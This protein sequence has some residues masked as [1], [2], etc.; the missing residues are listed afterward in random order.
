VYLC[1]YYYCD[2]LLWSD[3]S[4]GMLWSNGSCLSWRVKQLSSV[5]V[6]HSLPFV[7]SSS[8]YRKLVY[9]FTSTWSLGL[10]ADMD[11]GCLLRNLI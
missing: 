10:Q 7:L 8:L 11:T 1:H 9:L 6:R 3:G 4:D 2:G 5:R